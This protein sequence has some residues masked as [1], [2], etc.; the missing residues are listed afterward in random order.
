MNW[1]LFHLRQ[2]Q[3][4]YCLNS[5]CTMLPVLC[6]ISAWILL[7]RAGYFSRQFSLQ[8]SARPTGCAHLRRRA[9]G[10][11]N[12][13][14]QLVLIKTIRASAQVSG[15]RTLSRCSA[16]E[17]GA[18]ARCGGLQHRKHEAPAK[19]SPR[20]ST[21]YLAADNAEINM[22]NEFQ[23]AES[24]LNVCLVQYDIELTA[25]CKTLAELLTLGLEAR[26]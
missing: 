7:E 21:F 4:R 18:N 17:T 25:D 5:D 24:K 6:R 8:A 1:V 3:I 26:W 16:L 10:L 13:G 20:K 12:L 22:N 11:C 14:S 15:T 9:W 19:S 2:T 23:H